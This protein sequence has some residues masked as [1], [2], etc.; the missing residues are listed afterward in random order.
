MPSRSAIAQLPEKVRAELDQRLHASNFSDYE[1]LAGWLQSQGYEIS[2][3]SV[4]RYGSKL[5]ERMEMLRLS[6]QGAMQMKSVLGDDDAVVAE[7]SLQ[8]AQ[9][10]IFD[11]M[12]ERGADLEAK[13]IGM[14]TR[15]LADASRAGVGV[16][17]FQAEVKAKAEAAATETAEILRSEGISEAT[18]AEIRRKFLGIA[19]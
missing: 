9:G 11:L 1:G 6:T 5:E 7:M 14:I 8:L 10:L 16:K 13:E 19:G 4:H 18:A 3:S 12:V 2:K 15:A 17:K